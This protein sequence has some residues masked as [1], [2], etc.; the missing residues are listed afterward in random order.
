MNSP[1]AVAT[2][3]RFWEKIERTASCWLWKA[4]GTRDGYGQ[5]FP[6]RGA[7]RSI[8]AHRFSWI[9]HFGAIPEGLYVC[10]RCDNRRCVN[11]DHLF[12]GTALDNSQDMV[13]KGRSQANEAHHGAKLTMDTAREIRQRYADGNTTYRQLA[14]TYVTSVSTIADVI[15]HRQ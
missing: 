15:Q 6:G 4:S 13:S 2:E 10:H 8:S 9:L 5:M 12:L 7:H 1:F 14:G 11:P 3:Q